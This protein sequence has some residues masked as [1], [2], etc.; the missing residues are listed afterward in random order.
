MGMGIPTELAVIITRARHPA[1]SI[2]KGFPGVAGTTPKTLTGMPARE[3]RPE[4]V[5]P[6][7]PTRRSARSSTPAAAA[8][9]HRLP[10]RRHGHRRTPA[11]RHV[12]V[13]DLAYVDDDGWF[14]LAGRTGDWMRVDGE[15]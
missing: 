12:L 14:Y 3:V 2:G 8:C 7:T 10:Q 6:P 15:K 13:G 1:G 9:S 5:T 11:R 4:R